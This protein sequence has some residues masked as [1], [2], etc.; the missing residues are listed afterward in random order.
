[1]RAA[2]FTDERRAVCRLLFCL[3]TFA[4]CLPLARPEP[5]A[6]LRRR[7]ESLDH[8]GLDEVSAKRVE[9][10]DPEVVARRVGVATEVTE[11]L[12]QDEGW[13]ALGVGDGSLLG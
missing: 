8:L 2:L 10:A 3:F 7:D 6:V 12:L 11:V 9:L 5:L 4:F 1:M 13:V